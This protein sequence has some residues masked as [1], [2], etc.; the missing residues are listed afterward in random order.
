MNRIKVLLVEDNDVFLNVATEWIESHPRLEL[1]GTARDGNEALERIERLA[2]DLVLM[3]VAMPGMNGFEATRRIK[4]A[5]GAPLVVLTTFLDGRAARNEAWAAGADELIPK[6]HLTDGLTA[7][8]E[9]LP[10]DGSPR[11]AGSR[12]RKPSPDPPA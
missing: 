2:P 11:P 3:D 8:L 9:G 5:P 12:P 1:A 7:F 6:N 4:A 10:D